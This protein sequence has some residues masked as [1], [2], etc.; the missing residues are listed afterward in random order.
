M[1]SCIGKG[2]TVG[3]ACSMKGLQ[4]DMIGLKTAFIRRSELCKP[5][6][7]SSFSGKYALVNSS[8]D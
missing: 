7:S 3:Y 1:H 6:H 2:F 5:F 8:D 4:S